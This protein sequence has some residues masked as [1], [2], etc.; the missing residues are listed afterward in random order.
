MKDYANQVCQMAVG[1]RLTIV[2][3][4]LLVE[5]GSGVATFDLLARTSAINGEAVPLT[6]LDEVGA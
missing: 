5:R 1:W 3:L 2:D 4:A 6:I